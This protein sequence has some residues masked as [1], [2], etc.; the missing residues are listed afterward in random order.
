MQHV[1]TWRYYREREKRAR[2]EKRATIMLLLATI[3]VFIWLV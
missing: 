1:K 2:N 3:I